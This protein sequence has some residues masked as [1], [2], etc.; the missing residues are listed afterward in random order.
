MVI[1]NKKNINSLVKMQTNCQLTCMVDC[2]MKSVGR[3]L[4]ELLNKNDKELDLFVE[5]HTLLLSQ[6]RDKMNQVTDTNHKHDLKVNE[7]NLLQ[8]QNALPSIKKSLVMVNDTLPKEVTDM[9]E[10]SS[11]E[12]MTKHGIVKWY[13]EIMECLSWTL[14][15]PSKVKHT[16][17]SMAKLI[18]SIQDYIKNVSLSTDKKNDLLILWKNLKNV[19]YFLYTFTGKS[20]MTG[21][22]MSKKQ[23]MKNDMKWVKRSNRARGYCRK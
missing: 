15:R 1:K 16:M 11:S 22:R 4:V 9:I 7:T 20:N 21:K 19:L 8:L 14:L 6:L 5:K 12:D 18:K 23:C 10:K 3:L 2:E 17:E 13:E